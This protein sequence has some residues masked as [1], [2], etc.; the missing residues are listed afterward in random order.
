MKVNTTLYLIIV[1]FIFTIIWYINP[2]IFQ[3]W[4]NNYFLNNW[5]YIWFIFQIVIYSFIHGWFLHFISNTIF[6]YLFWNSLED[7]IWSKKYIVFFILTTI[8]N[9][10]FL[11]IFSGNNTTVWISGFCMALLSYYT[12]ELKKRKI[13]DY[14][15]GITW[16]I[17]NVLVW[18][19]DWISLVWHLFW[20]IFWVIFFY[21]NKNKTNKDE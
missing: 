21:F 3:Y 16:I 18:F 15:W 9:A 14:K 8:F 12:L 1:S 10:I 20:A 6:L 5:N 17:L 7:L 13:D 19:M 2:L 4:M 11:I